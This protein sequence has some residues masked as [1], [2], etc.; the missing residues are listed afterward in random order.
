MNYEHF[1]MDKKKWEPCDYRTC[2][3]VG[4][5]H[6]PLRT[7]D[8][9]STQDSKTRDDQDQGQHAITSAEK[10]SP[11]AEMPG[12]CAPDCAAYGHCE[13]CRHYKI[14]R[15]A[16]RWL[17]VAFFIALFF[18]GY[19]SCVHAQEFTPTK[20]P[21]ETKTPPPHTETPTWTPSV[22]ATVTVTPSSTSVPT[23]TP[24]GSVT[25]SPSSS[26]TITPSPLLTPSP[27]KTA[28]P[29]PFVPPSPTP[30]VPPS[31]P[32]PTTS[33]A[34]LF[35]IALLVLVIGMWRLRGTP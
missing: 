4:F 26:P 24:T 33:P 27:S 15:P 1:D 17:F 35:A 5:R 13:N 18:F 9:D 10:Y 2:S 12:V 16:R 14:K 11:E 3:Q 23:S 22:S 7:N 8:D 25:A 31:T 28:S 32:I 19:R 29:T 6:R 20:P 30:T 21:T 34:A